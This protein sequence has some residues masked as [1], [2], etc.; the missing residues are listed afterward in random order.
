[1]HEWSNLRIVFGKFIGRSSEYR[2]YTISDSTKRY[3][4][5]DYGA[6]SG[7]KLIMQAFLYNYFR[8]VTLV[9]P[10]VNNEVSF[11]IF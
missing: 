4:V 10:L 6:L 7:S 9:A 8:I 11:D 5:D 1:M 3:H 2:F